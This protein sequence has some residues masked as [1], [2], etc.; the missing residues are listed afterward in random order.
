MSGASSPWGPRQT[1][2]ALALLGIVIGLSPVL[3]SP[4]LVLDQSRWWA[5]AAVV[6][7]F[8]LAVVV[9]GGIDL[10]CGSILALSAVTLVRLHA[11]GGVPMGWAALAGLAVGT[12]AGAL[13]GIVIAAGRI[14]DLVVTLATLAIYRGLAQA[15]GG[16]RVYSNLPEAYRWIGEG[17]LLGV[18]PASWLV[19][20]AAWLAAY[21][22]LHRSRLG[23]Q[24][25][26][27]GSSPRGARLARVPITRVRIL[28]YSLSGLAAGV[29]SVLHTARSNTARSDDAIGLEL[30]AMAAVVLGGASIAG[31]RGSAPG[32]FIAVLCLGL[33]RTGLMLLG[34]PE[35]WQRMSAGVVLIGV[36]ILNERAAGRG[37]SR[38]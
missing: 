9:A 2:L 33:V 29:A 28:L 18:V 3:P 37:G 6:A 19:V 5:D 7:P 8:L 24:A 21:A 20:L 13:N 10:S 12:A 38:P 32:V 36:A 22:L 15:V 16:N 27:V 1:R 34:V 11:E 17:S 4:A 35:L 25:F 14:P 30:E 23:R 31:G 26:A